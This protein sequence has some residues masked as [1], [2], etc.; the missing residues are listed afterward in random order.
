MR[1]IATVICMLLP[2][3]AFAGQGAT[4][5]TCDPCVDYEETIYPTPAWQTIA[6]STTGQ[7]NDEYAYV[8]CAEAGGTYTFSTCDAAGAGGGSADYDTAL[9]VWSMSGAACGVQEICNDDE[10]SGG[11]SSLLSTIAF[12]APDDNDY[13]VVVDGF[14][15]N[16]G[17]Y[18]LAYMGPECSTPVDDSTWGQIKATYE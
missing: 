11:S 8:F 17:N 18:M 1:L 14:S 16:V 5:L 3:V 4:T 2:V 13:V 10:C 15:T 9:S 12:V 6:G 7:T